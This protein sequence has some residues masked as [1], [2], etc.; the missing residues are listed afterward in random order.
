M[1]KFDKGFNVLMTILFVC[2]AGLYIYL[3]IEM[4]KA[5]KANNS[6][7]EDFLTFEYEVSRIDPEGLFADSVA[8]NTG[9]FITGDKLQ[10]NHNINTGDLIRV[11]FNK[12]D[13]Q[14]GIEHVEVIA[15][16]Q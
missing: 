10:P 7:T 4:N 8:D 1:T 6:S 3:A 16:G 11:Y 2:F 5:E 15:N 13:L 14:E 12:E 9:I